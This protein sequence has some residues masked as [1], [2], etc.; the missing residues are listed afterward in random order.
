MNIIILTTILFLLV[1]VPL[2]STT[3]A[4]ENASIVKQSITLIQND[5]L[6][7]YPFV[8]IIHRDSNGNLLTY[9]E[10][11]KLAVIDNESIIRFMDEETSL[12]IV[13][14]V[15]QI[16][17][18]NIQVIVRKDTINVEKQKLIPDTVLLSKFLDED[19]NQ[20]TMLRLNHD[21]FIALPG[22]TVTY[23]WNFIRII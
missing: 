5:V 21:G 9:T 3:I 12:G 19:G 6:P 22:D 14:P 18:Y 11:D 20:I 4:Q 15:Y 1:L 17:E 2:M 16:G 10:S 23:Y 13:D 7:V 8:Q